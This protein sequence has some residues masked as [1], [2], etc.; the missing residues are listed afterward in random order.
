LGANLMPLN[1]TPGRTPTPFIS[2]FFVKG[3]GVSDVNG[4]GDSA[5]SNGGG[6]ASN[7]MTPRNRPSVLVINEV[8]YDAL[9]SDSNGDVFI[10]LVGEKGGDISGYSINLINGDDGAIKDTID[11][12]DGSI[13]RDDGIFLIADAEKGKPNTSRVAGADLIVNF[14]PQNG[15]DCIQLLDDTGKLLDALGYGASIANPAEN[16]LACFEGNSADDV[17]SGMSLSRTNSMD[18]DDNATDFTG[19]E[20]PTPGEI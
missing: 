17:A 11:I 3:D 7:V 6:A 10:E 19:M 5:A 14:D 16:G 20:A 8:M 9:G 18:T 13:I 2:S 12:L 4:N 1:Q 15:P